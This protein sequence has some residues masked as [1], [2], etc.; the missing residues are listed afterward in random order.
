MLTIDTTGADSDRRWSDGIQYHNGE[1]EGRPISD[2]RA[3]CR[4]RTDDLPLTRR[5]LW[6]SELRRHWTATVEKSRKEAMTIHLNDEQ[7]ARDLHD[8]VELA[9][10]EPATLCLQSRCATRLRYSPMVRDR[11]SALSPERREKMIESVAISCL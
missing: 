1:A 5:L 11:R 4:D 6:P 10:F 7:E 2:H 9:G 3:S 8:I